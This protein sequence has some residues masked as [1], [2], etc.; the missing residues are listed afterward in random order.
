M[1]SNSNISAVQVAMGHKKR[2]TTEV[3]AKPMAALTGEVEDKAAELMMRPR[4]VQN[5]VH[6][7]LMH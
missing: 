6:G 5:H 4:H 3:Y 1:V 7:E 2:A